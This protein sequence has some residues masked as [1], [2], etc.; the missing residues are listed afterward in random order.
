[1]GIRYDS[2][3]IYGI[4]I[5]SEQTKKLVN[6]DFVD[7]DLIYEPEGYTLDENFKISLLSSS[8]YYGCSFW[9]REFLLGA[10]IQEATAKKFVEIQ[11]TIDKD[12]EA[13]C[14]KYDIPYSAPIIQSIPDVC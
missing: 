1:M 3:C 11:E 13:F 6:E 10:D 9:E 5:S 2:R 14:L 7:L 4:K 8:S 12:L